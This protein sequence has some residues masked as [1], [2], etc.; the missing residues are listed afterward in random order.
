MEAGARHAA[1]TAPSAPPARP[2]RPTPASLRRALPPVGRSPSGLPPLLEMRVSQQNSRVG[3][4]N[5]HRI[6]SGTARSVGG[7]SSPYLVF[8]TRVPRA[9]AEIRSEGGS[10]V[11]V[12]LRGEFF[13]EVAGPVEH[14]L[15]VEIPFTGP[16]GHRHT[17]VFREWVSA[18]DE[19]NALMRSVRR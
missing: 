2:A 14:C 11:F 5:V 9:V 17:I 18:L 6:L 4:R 1:A 3:F 7:G 15:G 19:I 12:P 8:I 10:Y 16:K 13:P